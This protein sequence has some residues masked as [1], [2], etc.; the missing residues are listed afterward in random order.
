MKVD[1]QESTEEERRYVMV[2]EKRQR[3]SRNVCELGK[4]YGNDHRTKAEQKAK[5]RIVNIIQ[6][7]RSIHAINL[8]AYKLW[9]PDRDCRRLTPVRVCMYERV[10]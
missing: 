1:D 2:E 10:D 8:S 9:T 3:R 4:T 7:N 5:Q 6:H